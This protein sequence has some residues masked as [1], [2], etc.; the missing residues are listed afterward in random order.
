ME[1]LVAPK[2]VWSSSSFSSIFLPSFKKKDKKDSDPGSSDH[3]LEGPKRA[4]GPNILKLELFS[5]FPTRLE[6]SLA[7]I[8]FT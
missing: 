5:T 7:S 2:L 1:H 4:W 6:Q 3:Q 8:I